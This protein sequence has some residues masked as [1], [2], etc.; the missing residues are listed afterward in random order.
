MGKRRIVL[1]LALLGTGLVLLSSALLMTGR[2]AEPEL[3]TFREEEFPVEPTAAVAGGTESAPTP[4]PTPFILRHAT[5]APTLEPDAPPRLELQ[6]EDP[7]VIP[8][9]PAPFADPGCTAWDDLDGVDVPVEAGPTAPVC[10]GIT[11]QARFRATQ[12][13]RSY[14]L[15][16]GATDTATLEFILERYA[17]PALT[18]R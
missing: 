14:F 15:R 10:P 12:G 5:A 13:N 17:S 16:F 9:G 1:G 7:L 18:P 11:H 3:P 8:A 6:R 4:N 2:A